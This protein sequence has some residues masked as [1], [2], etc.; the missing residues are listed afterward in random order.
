MIDINQVTRILVGL[1]IVMI[2]MF[3]I[4]YLLKRVTAGSYLG[5]KEITVVGN[6]FL[7]NKERLVLLDVEGQRA[8]IG[9]TAHNIQTLLI[10]EKSVGKQNGVEP[11]NSPSQ[12]QKVLKQQETK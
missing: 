7:G 11:V 5:N 1:M 2:V 4:T 9:V 12:F 6:L 3:I 10:M 8:L